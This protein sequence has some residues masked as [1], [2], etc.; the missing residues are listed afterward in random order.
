MGIFMY[1]P[2]WLVDDYR[3]QGWECVYVRPYGLNNFS[4]IARYL[5]YD[6]N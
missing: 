4:Y 1:I 2:D 6:Y 3:A 5:L